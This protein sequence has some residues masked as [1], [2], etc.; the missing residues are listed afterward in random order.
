MSEIREIDEGADYV[1]YREAFDIIGANV[2]KVGEEEL[3]L[4]L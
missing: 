2:R 3:R 1:G 4:D